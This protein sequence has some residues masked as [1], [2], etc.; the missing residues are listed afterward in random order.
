MEKE[1][2]AIGDRAKREQQVQSGVVE[3]SEGDER[4]RSELEG[5]FERK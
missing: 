3:M 5:L 1:K 4:L 2:K